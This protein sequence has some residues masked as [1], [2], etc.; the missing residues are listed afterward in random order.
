VEIKDN[1]IDVHTPYINGPHTVHAG[2]VGGGECIAG[3][4]SCLLVVFPRPKIML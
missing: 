3:N 2:D 4:R 1:R